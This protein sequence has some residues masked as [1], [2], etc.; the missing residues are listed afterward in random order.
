MK[1]RLAGPDFY[2]EED[3]RES[4]QQWCDAARAAPPEDFPLLTKVARQPKQ[5]RLDGQASAYLASPFQRL[6]PKGWG[7]VGWGGGGQQTV[8]EVLKSLCCRRSTVRA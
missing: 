2:L 6:P 3:G 7:G 8:V 1:K 4:L 5:Q